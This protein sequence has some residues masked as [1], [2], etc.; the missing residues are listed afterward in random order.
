VWHAQARA[1]ANRKS[2]NKPNFP[3]FEPGTARFD[4][5]YSIITNNLANDP[6]NPGTRFYDRSGLLH[7]H[8]EYRFK[9]GFADFTFGANARQYNPDSKG[10]IFSDTADVRIH[11]SEFG[12]YGGF[13]KKLIPEKLKVNITVRADKNQNFDMV[14][15]PA[16]SFIYTPDID[17]TFRL[18]FSSAVRNPT[19]AD[20][21]LNLDVGRAQ[22]LGNISG[23]QGLI[24]LESFIDYLN[25]R[26]RDTLIF[27]DEH[28]L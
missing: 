2:P 15:S 4:S 23:Y 13:G 12:V 10:T 7:V 14:F 19:L 9:T 16:A 1:Y 25:T 26:N 24:T 22:L 28:R 8:G 3:F 27:F 20:Q 17:N 11:N 5:M 6:L 18:S 21:Y